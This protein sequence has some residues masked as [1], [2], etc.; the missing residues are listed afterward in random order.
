M[1]ICIKTADISYAAPMGAGFMKPAAD[2]D[3]K[4]GNKNGSDLQ[5]LPFCGILLTVVRR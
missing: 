5:S 1:R 4:N 3:M 2:G